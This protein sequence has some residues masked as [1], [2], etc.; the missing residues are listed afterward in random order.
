VFE[1]ERNV[2]EPSRGSRLNVY[3]GNYEDYLW[4]KEGGAQALAVATVVASEPMPP[5]PPPASSDAPA[6]EKIKRLNPIKL[7]Q[8][9]ERLAAVE[10]EIPRVE[11]WIAEAEQALAVYVSQEETQRLST[12]LDVLRER[13]ASLNSE[14]EELAT[15]LEGQ[16]EG[17]ATS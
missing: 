2:E 15:Q 11:S 6:A 5:L 9:Q 12:V 16:M 17:Q 7:R 10:A 13:Q 4:R 3:P 1:V 8:M 14:W